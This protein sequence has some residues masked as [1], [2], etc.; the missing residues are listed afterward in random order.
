MTS[1]LS[2]FKRY[3]YLHGTNQEHLLGKLAS[4]RCIRFSDQV[5]LGLFNLL[6]AGNEVEV[7]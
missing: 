4:H 1:V 5:I 3:I 2:T 6:L 7:L